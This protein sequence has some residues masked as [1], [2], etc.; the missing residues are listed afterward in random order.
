MKGARIVYS[1]E[2]MAWLAA[3]RGLVISDYFRAFREVFP[4]HTA[5]L[6]NLHALRKRKGWKVGRAPGRLAGR[7]RLYSAAEISWLRDNCTLPFTTYHQT[8]CEAFGRTDVSAQNLNGLRKREGWKTGRTG[9][10]VKGGE[11]ANKGKRCPEGTGGRHPNARRTQFKKGRAPH[12]TKF[13]GHERVNTDGYVEISIAETN[14]HTGYERR[15]VHKHVHLWEAINGPVPEGH[16]LKCLD[17]DKINTDPSN[18]E[19]IPRGML[20]LL[21]G[22]R[23]TRRLPYD[24]A[25]PEVRSTLLAIAKVEHRARQLRKRQQTAPSIAPCAKE[26]C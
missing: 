11:P 25:A 20:P 9:H 19:A 14:P 16:C 21:N 5:T 2:Q 22:G 4:G 15:Y 13:L 23:A 12:N 26:A 10:F 6:E 17:G 3:N 18:W 1:A 8:F 24:Q 7:R